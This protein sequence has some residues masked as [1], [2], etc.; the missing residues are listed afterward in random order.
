MRK[1]KLNENKLYRLTEIITAAVF[2]VCLAVLVLLDNRISYV[3]QSFCKVPNTV[4]VLGAF[5]ILS[6]YGFLMR[7]RKRGTGWEQSVDSGSM[8]LKRKLHRRNLLILSVLLLAF[9]IIVAWQIYFKTGW[10]CGKLVQMSQEIAFQ[11]RSIGDDLYFS[12]Y[13]NNVLL[14]AVFA[15]VL[16]LTQFLGFHADYFPLVIVGCFL[17]NAA[18]FF[19]ADSVAGVAKR[20]WVPYASWIVYV[21]LVGLSPWISIPYSDTY[22]IFFTCFC[23]WLYIH[24]NERNRYFIWML[25]GFFTWIGGYIKPT[26]LLVLFVMAG[27][28]IWKKICAFDKGRFKKNML[29]TV[30][31]IVSLGLGIFLAVQVNGFARAKMECSLDDSKRFTP[32]HYL[33][34]GLNYKTGG[35]Y[36]QWDVNFSADSPDVKSR[37]EKDLAQIRYRISSM[38]PKGLTFHTVRK[39]LTNFNDGTFAWGNEGEFYWNIPPK[40]TFL[41]ERLRDYYYEDGKGYSCFQ[42]VTQGFWILV[43]M[44]IPFLLLRGDTEK[45]DKNTVA[46]LSVLAISCFVMVFEARARYLYLYV[47]F[48]IFVSSLG[49]ERLLDRLE[50]RKICESA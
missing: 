24:K 10:D 8:K 50:G 28:E 44:F 36:D 22:S 17:V 49:L 48:F 47:P 7:K 45:Q 20:S 5:C 9:Q 27:L 39:L 1:I 46:V 37:N 4:F 13:P 42:A 19:M 29:V 2:L 11:G 26:V 30:L 38:G 34:M 6:V 3:Y 21:V 35:T 16:R 12:R 31:W 32:A 43:L 23:V 33:M 14:V 18:G 41:A 40:E 15:G 25:I